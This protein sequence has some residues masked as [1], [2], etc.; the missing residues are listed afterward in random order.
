M[1][2]QEFRAKQ[3]VSVELAQCGL[4]V[5]LRPFDMATLLIRYPLRPAAIAKAR[6]AAALSKDGANDEAIAEAVGSEAAEDYYAFGC[7]L[8]C[9][10]AVEPAFVMDKELASDTALWVGELPTR[11][12]E[13]LAHAAMEIQGLT[14]EVASAAAPFR[15][16]GNAG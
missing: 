13:Q 5:T 10:A 6:E 4:T 16:Q 8:I 15:D 7:A 14:R 1:N 11:D 12:R 3:N 9:C 2:L